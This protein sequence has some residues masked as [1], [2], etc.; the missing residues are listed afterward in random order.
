MSLAASL[1][2]LPTVSRMLEA[3]PYEY[4]RVVIGYTVLLCGDSRVRPRDGKGVA[5]KVEGDAGLVEPEVDMVRHRH[6]SEAAARHQVGCRHVAS[7]VG[8]AFGEVS[9]VVVALRGVGVEDLHAERLEH[10]Q[11][12][13][14]VWRLQPPANVARLLVWSAEW[15]DARKRPDAAL[16][17]RTCRLL[18]LLGTAAK[19]LLGG[20]GGRPRVCAKR[21]SQFLEALRD[22]NEGLLLLARRRVVEQDDWDA[23]LGGLCGDLVV[24]DER[25]KE[26]ARD[27]DV[28][29]ALL[30]EDRHV[31]LGAPVVG[32]G[33]AGR[34]VNLLREER[35][36]LRRRVRR[37]V[38]RGVR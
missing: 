20:S 33:A 34:D 13:V 1:S 30:V 9:L 35:L 26:R 32:A 14:A 27:D 18:E 12:R 25:G 23:P 16:R 3:W 21:C 22:L 29:P 36:L 8:P 19:R 6:A 31:E 24:D 10:C 11:S 7:V 37:E 5:R 28:G 4:S 2:L 38:R 17:R 15:D